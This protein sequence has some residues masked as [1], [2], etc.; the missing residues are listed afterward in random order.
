MLATT[1]KSLAEVCCCTRG[2]FW[3]KCSLNDCTFLYFTKLKRLR[4][5]L[6]ATIYA[7]HTL[8][9]CFQSWI[10]GRNKLIAVIVSWKA[11]VRLLDKNINININL[12]Y[13]SIFRILLCHCFFLLLS[14]YTTC[15]FPLPP[16]S[17]HIRILGFKA[18]RIPKIMHRISGKDRVTCGKNEYY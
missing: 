12:Y 13:H 2:L 18:T 9:K 7:L 11:D 16:Y 5:H 3:R 14:L 8:K 6:E 4:E 17:H 1:W 10:R 15:F